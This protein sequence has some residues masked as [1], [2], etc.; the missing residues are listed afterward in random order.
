MGLVRLIGNILWFVLGGVFMGLAWWLVGVIAFISVIGIPW[1][2]ACFVIGGFT[3]WPFGRE[4]VSRRALSGREDIGTGPLG[5]AGNIIWL[6][7]F[8]WWLAL[9]HVAS[10]IA[11]FITIIGIPFGIQHLKLALISLWPIGV[12]IIPSDMPAGRGRPL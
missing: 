1:G 5:A 7:L 11:D 8:G 4:A 3:F 10:A 2:R 9:G 12:Q 6:V